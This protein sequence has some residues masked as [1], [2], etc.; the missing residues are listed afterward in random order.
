MKKFLLTI[1]MISSLVLP[2]GVKADT[3]TM[4]L[5]DTLESENITPLFDVDE[6]VETDDQ[7]T[8]YLFRGEGCIHCR[9]FLEFLNSIT[10]EYGSKFK[11]WKH[12][13]KRED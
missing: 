11:K 12:W 8:I 7:V 9:N 13:C 3:Q 1:I 4:D 2:I 6:Y 5:V 10:E